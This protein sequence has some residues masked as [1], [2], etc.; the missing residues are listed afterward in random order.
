MA[1]IQIIFLISSKDKIPSVLSKNKQ[2]LTQYTSKTYST[3]N[4]KIYFISA[5]PIIEPIKVKKAIR[6]EN[7]KH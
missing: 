3:I 4:L 5:N 6:K 1:E 2:L 7:N